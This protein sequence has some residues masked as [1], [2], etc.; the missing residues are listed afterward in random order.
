[1]PAIDLRGGHV[2]RLIQ[3]DFERET[4]Y[5]D[6]PASVASD[7][8]DA[9]ARWLH[10]VDLDGAREGAPRQGDIIRQIVARVGERGRCEVAGGL[11]SVE[12]VDAALGA[13]AARAVVGTAALL[14]PPF[15]RDLVDR[16][17]S[18]RVAVAIDVRDGLA[19]GDGWRP[20]ASGVSPEAAITTLADQGVTTFEVTAVNRDGLLGGPDVDLL[21]RLVALD[22]G[23]VI[24]SGGIAR[25][26]D[27]VAVRDLGCGGA[28]V[29][30]A[31]YEGRFTVADALA[32]SSG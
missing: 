31:L 10:L 30:R 6:D 7:F 26:E 22:R 3:G 27:L 17:G 13:G 19:L 18:G 24:A 28:I 4:R 16:H 5:G 23:E 2:V 25:V 21:G 1:L 14:D 32:A 9:G 12:A 29:G 15:A 20:G 8:V 11:R